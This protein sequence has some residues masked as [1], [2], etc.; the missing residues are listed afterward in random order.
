MS[1]PLYGRPRAGSGGLTEFNRRYNSILQLRAQNR[2]MLFLIGR[3]EICLLSLDNQQILLNKSFSSVTHCSQGID[4]SD[5]FGFICKEQ[6][7]P[8]SVYSNY[9][10][11]DGSNSY[12]NNCTSNSSSSSCL[13]SMMEFERVPDHKAS[14]LTSSSNNKLSS[15]H[16]LTAAAATDESQYQYVG[17]IFR[18]ENEK[19]VNE[20]MY[21]LRQAFR[22]AHHAIQQSKTKNNVFCSDC[23]LRYYN[24]LCVG[25]QDAS[26]EKAQC[27]ILN[28]IGGELSAGEQ[29]EIMSG[30][31]GVQVNSI[32]E[33][34]EI[35]MSLLKR[36]YE[37]KQL[38]H[39][40]CRTET[41]N[42]SQHKTYSLDVF[43]QRAKKSL[44][45]SFETIASL[46]VSSLHSLRLC[47]QHSVLCYFFCVLALTMF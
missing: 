45:T 11:L 38:K 27:T 15:N 12:L 29:K 47:V 5:H 18:G 20:I 17:Y 37:K 36:F 7:N 4:H 9:R 34:N 24:K 3:F 21:S 2:T 40:T 19:L 41:T 28:F 26:V 39:P 46:K 10:Q 14:N 31:E 8:S 44:S 43:R 25:L 23:P 33:Q 6:K 30:Y 13:D 42:H 1:L 35:L 16:D 22:N 32:R